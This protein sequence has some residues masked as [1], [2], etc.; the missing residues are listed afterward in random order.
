MR[1]EE[2]PQLPLGEEWRYTLQ[3]YLRAVS[4]K[5]NQMADGKTSA[6]DNAVPAVPTTGQFAQGDFVRNSAPTELGVATSKY[7]ITG[8]LCTV[9]GSP[10][11]FVQCRSLT[12]N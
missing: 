9:G 1:L 10:G 2:N 12:G 7:V 5:V 6:I 4:Q 8:W 3:R 11:T